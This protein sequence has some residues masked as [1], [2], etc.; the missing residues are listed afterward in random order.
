MSKLIKVAVIGLILASTSVFANSNTTRLLLREVQYSAD[1]PV[2]VSAVDTLRD[3]LTDSDVERTLLSVLENI[4]EDR[5]VRMAAVKALSTQGD[6]KKIYDT[7]VR[8]HDQSND[9][10]FRATCLQAL[11]KAAP[12][13]N[14]VQRGLIS[15]LLN[16]PSVEIRRASAFGLMAST[17]DRTAADALTNVALNPRNDVRQRI[18]AIKSLYAKSTDSRLRGN[19]QAIAENG[20]DNLEVRVAA[21][22]FMTTF[23]QGTRARN[24]LERLIELG[25]N[26][27]VRSMAAQAIRFNLRENDVRW[28]HLPVDPRGNISR[29]PFEGAEAFNFTKVDS[30]LENGGGVNFNK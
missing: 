8:A 1:T 28:F 23:P 25:G 24:V 27:S 17:S 7:I 22:R 9:T 21:V 3:F 11:Y 14:Q 6:E 13:N 29:D 19:I 26:S 12:R 18:E 2:R 4:G 30:S 15:N 16:A 10:V 20:A 5:Q